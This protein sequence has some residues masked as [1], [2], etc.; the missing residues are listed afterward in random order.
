MCFG[1][2]I[3]SATLSMHLLSVYRKSGQFLAQRSNAARH[4]LSCKTPKR[5]IKFTVG[6]LQSM[7]RPIYRIRYA[8]FSILFVTKYIFFRLESRMSRKISL[9][10]HVV[11]KTFTQSLKI[12][13]SKLVLLKFCSAYNLHL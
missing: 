7:H 5:L 2:G 10:P 4:V 12:Y 8:T 11:Y 9:P 13:P 6:E 3:K 1:L